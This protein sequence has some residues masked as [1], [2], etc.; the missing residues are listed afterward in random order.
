VL[1]AFQFVIAAAGAETMRF[2][3]YSEYLRC[4]EV[5]EGIDGARC[6]EVIIMIQCFL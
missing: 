6:R 1:A 3:E 4:D 2:K 5:V